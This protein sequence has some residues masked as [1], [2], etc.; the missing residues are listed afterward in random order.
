MIPTTTTEL[1]WL[2][3]AYALLAFLLLCLCLATRWH[4]AVK[5]VMVVVV[6]AFFLLHNQVLRGIAGWPAD[7]ALPPPFCAAVGRV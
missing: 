5:A 2:G 7:D 1:L 6:S 3:I 4:W